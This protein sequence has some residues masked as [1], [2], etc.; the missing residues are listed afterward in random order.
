MTGQTI[1]TPDQAEGRAGDGAA[2]RPD[3]ATSVVITMRQLGVPGLPRNYELFYEAITAGNRELTNAL[4]A[5]GG[6]PAQKQ[7]DE[8][9]RRFLRRKDDSVVDEAHVRV[10]HK[11]DEIISLLK[12]ERRSMETYDQILGETSQGLSGR[13]SI[14]REFLEKIISVTAT[15]TKSSIANR[16]HTVLSISDKSEELQEVRLELEEYKRLADTDPLTQLHNRRAFDRTMS[17]IYDNNRNVAFGALILIDID[18]FKSVNDRFGH[19]VGD[20]ILQI[21]ANIIRGGVKDDVFI[22]R[23]GGEE[24]ALVLNGMGEEAAFRLGDEIRSAVAEAPFVNVGSGTNY[25]PITVSL[26]ICM[27]TQAQDPDDL[28]IKADRAL[29]AS[30]AG[31]RNRTTRFSSLSEGNFVKN[32][33]LYRKA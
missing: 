25:G 5:L 19:P 7:L 29:Y 32:W 16:E 17:A 12:K 13:Q 14:S 26:G 20:R 15:A 31:G 10:A 11:L 21:V 4:S 28:Y 3:A 6:R 1:R 33:L 24:F 18:R 2:N 27:A 22:A 8:I 30:K 9:A 23:T